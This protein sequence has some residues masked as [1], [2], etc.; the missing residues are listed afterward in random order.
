MTQF[1]PYMNVSDA[2]KAYVNIDMTPQRIAAQF[3]NTLV[4]AMSKNKIYP[5]VKA[6]DDG[7]LQ[8]K[9]QRRKDALYRLYDQ[10]V[11]ESLQTEAGLPLEPIDAYIPHDALS[12]ETYFKLQDRSPKEIRF[13]EMLGSVFNEIKFDRVLNRKGIYDMVVV[14]VE[15]TKIDKVGSKYL[16]RKCTPTSLIY[17][18]FIIGHFAY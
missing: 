7:S 8:E 10:K 17:N 1:L 16:P 5:C 4:E 6:I 12:A 9:D 13:E 11:I 2:N 14:N 18:F 15:C 3:V